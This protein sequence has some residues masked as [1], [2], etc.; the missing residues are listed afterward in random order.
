M[1]F[2]EVHPSHAAIRTWRDFFVHITPGG[3]PNSSTGGRVELLQPLM[4]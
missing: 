3:R 2:H 4:R 1:P